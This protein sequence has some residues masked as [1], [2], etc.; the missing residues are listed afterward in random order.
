MKTIFDAL[1]T[2]ISGSALSTAIGGHYYPIQAPVGTPVPFVVGSIIT[3]TTTFAL[4]H[5]FV[6]VLIEMSVCAT[7]ATT[8]HTISALVFTLFDETTLSGLS[9]YTQL[10]TLEREA[11]QPIIEDGVYRY[12][13]EYRLRLKKS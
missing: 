2:K 7:D 6:D 4:S 13:I 12:I 11:A 1:Y 8:M 5:T 3:E 9:G 10:G